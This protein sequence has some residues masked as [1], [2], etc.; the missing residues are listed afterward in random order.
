MRKIRKSPRSFLSRDVEKALL[1]ETSI[2]VFNYFRIHA[3][4]EIRVVVIAG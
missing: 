2:M 4:P 3:K 1:T